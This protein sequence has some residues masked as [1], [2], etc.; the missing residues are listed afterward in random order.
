MNLA[1]GA[2]AEPVERETEADRGSS[3]EEGMVIGRYR[4]LE[5]LGEGGF[6][7]VWGADQMEPVRR[8]VALKIIKLGMDT[9]Q[10]VAR[11]EAERQALA[12][13]DHPN[14]ARVLDADATTSGRPFF[15]MELVHGTPITRY[16]GQAQLE[17]EERLGLFIKVCHA[18]QHAHQ[19]GI[20]HRDIKPSNI[21]VELQDGRPAPKVIDFGIAK[22]TQGELTDKTIYTQFHQLIGTPAYMSPE[23]ADS[24]GLDIDTRSD[25]YSLGV[26]L[27]E[28]LTG[29]TPFDTRELTQ[30]GLEGVRKIIRERE[31]LRPSTRLSQLQ[32]S[33][34][35]QIA[36]RKSK[37]EHDLD[38]IVMK[39]LEKDRRRRYDTVNGLATDL[40]R[41]LDNEPVTARP[42]SLGYR[43]QRAWRRHKMAFTAAALVAVALVGGIAVSTWQAVVA[44]SERQVAQEERDRAQEA[45]YEATRLQQAEEQA[46]HRAEAGEAELRRLSLNLAF[47]RGL[48]LCE[49]GKVREGMLWLVRTLDLAP[50]HE[51]ELRR[52]LRENLAA[53]RF[54]VHPLRNIFPHPHQVYAAEFSPD[55]RHLLT[56]CADAV[57]R[58]WD[59]DS[60]RLIREY[61]GHE[62]YIHD[63]GFS[64][65]GAR[66]VTAAWDKTARTWETTSARQIGPPLLH[67]A[68]V[69]AGRFSPDGSRLLTAT[70]DGTAVF[71]DAETLVK[72]DELSHTSGLHYAVFSPDGSMILAAS[73]ESYA[74]LW[75][76]TSG[77]EQVHAFQHSGRA[78]AAA[79]SPDGRRAATG[80]EDQLVQFWDVETGLPDGSPLRHSGDVHALAFSPDGSWLAAAVLDNSARLWDARTGEAFET[81]L[82]HQT[83]VEAI[84]VSPDGLFVASGSTDGRVCHWQIEPRARP[85]GPE[86]PHDQ[87]VFAVAYSP[88]GGEII[89]GCEDGK[90]RL[91][92]VRTG[93]LLRE[94]PHE[95]GVQTAAFSPVGF[96]VVTGSGDAAYIWNMETGEQIGKPLKHGQMVRSATFSSDGRYVLTGSLDQTAQLWDAATGDPVGPPFEQ[97]DASI[98]S[99]AF[100][101]DGEFILTASH[102]HLVHLWDR[103]TRRAIRSFRHRALVRGVAFHPEGSLIASASDDNT[104]RFWNPNTGESV[105][106]PLIHDGPVVN[107]SFSTDGARLLTTASR[108]AR[109]WDVATGRPIG[110]PVRHPSLI[111]AAALSPDGSRLVIAGA[112]GLT[113]MWE[114]ATEPLPGDAEQVRLWVQVLTG[115]ELDESGNARLLDAEVWLERRR[116]LETQGGRLANMNGSLNSP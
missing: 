111:S 16:C 8:R 24:S 70:G 42:P 63:V 113:R 15:V 9:R 94:L 37:I 74:Y 21:L 105:G 12:L 86:F 83:P 106:Q 31:P 115:M 108:A 47:D 49:G 97:Q 48:A 36:N 65:D 116:A 73:L 43:L 71:W 67:D 72:T 46:R 109:L 41:H 7:T 40:Q 5:R 32:H 104:A 56:G 114:V 90:A 110:A 52:V 33:P 79:F 44:G 27:Y 75:V 28:L 99:V 25:I 93:D 84:A 112:D 34:Q 23:Q 22:A 88:N 68:G 6:G 82:E 55:G 77:P 50:S 20:I 2:S 35:S 59:L 92:D 66:I 4:L 101:P 26:L 103:A 85:V 11:F 10:V 53:W 3:E 18:I 102:N 87:M 54:R 81:P 51:I 89:T 1:L 39:C 91:W 45:R 17:I 69:Y 107:L 64:P 13:M 76:L 78:Y 38:W 95:K 96:R 100:S 14:I 19:K 58:L 60:G 98:W 30:A 62:G 29:T 80:G 57:A 61:T